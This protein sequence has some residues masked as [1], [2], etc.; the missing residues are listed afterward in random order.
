MT[1]GFTLIET[2]ATTATIVTLIGITLPALKSARDKSRETMC[3]EQLK[4]WGGVITYDRANYKGDYPYIYEVRDE[5][6]YFEKITNVP[7]PIRLTK[8]PVSEVVTRKPYWCPSNRD[9]TERNVDWGGM[10]YAYDSTRYDK[11]KWT[12]ISRFNENFNNSQWLMN[13]IRDWHKIKEY[14]V[15][16]Y[17]L[18]VKRINPW[19]R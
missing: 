3:S 12:S 9:T 4:D 14:N 15:L 13:D 10:S 2:L 8:N 7:K 1:K 17:D 6:A 18:S 19:Q 11:D 16:K 5:G